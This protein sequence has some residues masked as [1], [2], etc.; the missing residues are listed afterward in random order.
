MQWVDVGGR[1]R[2]KI[3]LKMEWKIDCILVSFFMILV[4]CGIQVGAKLFAIRFL[5]LYG[6]GLLYAHLFSMFVKSL[7]LLI[8][9]YN[10]S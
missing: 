10:L 6:H 1:Q 3:L 8:I 7:L 9:D 2:L 5:V 4:D